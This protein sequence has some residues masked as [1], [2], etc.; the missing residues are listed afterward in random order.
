M[1]SKAETISSTP[2]KSKE[3]T[4]V[5]KGIY[6]GSD[7]WKEPKLQEGTGAGRHQERVLVP[8]TSV[9]QGSSHGL[10]YRAG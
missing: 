5:N 3:I 9:L 8:S 1:I 6:D 7:A 2:E 10:V 4:V